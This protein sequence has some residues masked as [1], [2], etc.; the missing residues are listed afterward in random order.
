MRK[1]SRV[2]S[3][4]VC[5]NIVKS[6][7][8]YDFKHSCGGKR[9][10]DRISHKLYWS[11]VR[12]GASC[13]QIYVLLVFA[14]IFHSVRATRGVETTPTVRFPFKPQKRRVAPP[15]DDQRISMSSFV[16]CVIS[17]GPFAV[18]WIISSIRTPYLPLI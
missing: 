4:F 3:Y 13:V 16:L 18:I 6:I 14:R 7:C 2:F 11:A 17:R 10:L 9:D 12:G 15:F 8:F 1:I 5:K